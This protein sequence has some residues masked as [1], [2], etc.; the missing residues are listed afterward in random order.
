MKEIR[1]YSA[2]EIFSF[3][4]PKKIKLAVFVKS[5]ELRSDGVSV[6]VYIKKNEFVIY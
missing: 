5:R 6:K 4:R 1:H 2:D 3:G